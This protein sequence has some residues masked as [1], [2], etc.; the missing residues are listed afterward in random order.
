MI[1]PFRI[2]VPDK[3]LEQIRT[4][5]A[6]YPWHEMPDDGGWAYGTHLGYM[7]ELCAY[8]LNEFDWRKQEAA[9]NRFSHFHWPT[10]NDLVGVLTML[11][12]SSYRPCRGLGSQVA[13]RDRS[14]HV[15]WPTSSTV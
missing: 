6:N 14:A 9:I 13:R 12:M 5:V 7:K 8:W 15:K 11:S 10:R 4:Q 1:H 2:D 3:T